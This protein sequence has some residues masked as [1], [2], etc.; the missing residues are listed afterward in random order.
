MDNRLKQLEIKKLLTEYD[1]LNID[2]EIKQEIDLILGDKMD[3]D[4]GNGL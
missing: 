2:G 4:A 1:Y 3:I